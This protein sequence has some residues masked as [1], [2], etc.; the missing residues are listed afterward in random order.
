MKVKVY[1][2]FEVADYGDG[3][4]DAAMELIPGLALHRTI[5]GGK[6][7]LF[8]IFSWLLW[9]FTIDIRWGK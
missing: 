2:A 5:Y 4:Y 9:S 1:G 7:S 3:D 6:S 8:I